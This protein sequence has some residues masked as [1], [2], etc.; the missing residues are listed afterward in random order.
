MLSFHCAPSIL[1]VYGGCAAEN[2]NHFSIFSFVFLCYL[3]LT[4][5]TRP[6]WTEN[7]VSKAEPASGCQTRLVQRL[8]QERWIHF[9]F[10]LFV[11]RLFFMWNAHCQ[12][13]TAPAFATLWPHT[14]KHT[15]RLEVGRVGSVENTNNGKGSNFSFLLFSY[16]T[17]WKYDTMRVDH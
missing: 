6:T 11:C 9:R 4:H 14:H 8:V 13:E 7:C 2:G 1:S 17:A 3:L 16:V 12:A 5:T 10:F 15:R